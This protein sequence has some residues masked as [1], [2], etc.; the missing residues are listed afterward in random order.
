MRTNEYVIAAQS[1]R[2]AAPRLRALAFALAPILSLTLATAARAQVDTIETS[3]GK[4]VQGKVLTEGYEGLEVQLKQGNT[5]RKIEWK[6]VNSIQYG[7]APEYTD[8]AAK[9]D[10]MAPADA[11]SALE[12]L[13]AD[14]KL[15]PILRQQVLFRIASIQMK[16]GDADA[17]IAAWQDLAKAFPGGRYSDAAAYGV[18]ES[19]LAKNAPADAAKALDALASDAKSAN[20]GP[21]FDTT[22]SLAKARLLEAQNNVGGAR[23]AYETAEKAGN[24][25]PDQAAMTSLGIARCLQ[26]AGE[27]GD[28]ETR[29]RKLANSADSP[30]SVKA[31][32]W[33]GLGDLQLEQGRKKRDT[34]LLTLALLAYLR[35]V[36]VYLPL[37]GEPTT[38]HK[39]ALAGAALC[40]ES[41][42]QIDASAK[43]AYTAKAAEYRERRKRLYGD[44]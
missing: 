23:A 30:R 25:A 43:Q 7:G 42:A 27:L 32:A 33:N 16:K 44:S 17:A 1:F 10:S 18:V 14:S 34:E 19:N 40:C 3:D 31:G 26:Q 12:K 9:L 37:D 29:F 22:V 41:I 36:L 13:K 4:S 28:A 24:L 20:L 11:L 21:R 5:K 39:R 35:P 15:R 8:L 2:R 6:E 38:E